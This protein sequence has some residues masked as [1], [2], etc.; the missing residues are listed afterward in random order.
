MLFDL[1]CLCSAIA[2]ICRSR[3]ENRNSIITHAVDAFAIT[4]AALVVKYLFVRHAKIRYARQ[5]V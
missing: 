2:T 3:Y 4:N 1:L 5:G